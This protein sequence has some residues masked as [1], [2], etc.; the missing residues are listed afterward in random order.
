MKKPVHLDFFVD[1]MIHCAD[2]AKK[3][4]ADARR[5][6]SVNRFSTAGMLAISSLEE[7]GKI[8]LLQIFGALYFHRKEFGITEG[9]FWKEF[10]KMW[11]DHR[12]KQI[13]ASWIDLFLFDK[14]AI[15]LA[16]HSMKKGD[17][18]ELRNQFLYVDLDNS[19]REWILPKETNRSKALEFVE[20]AEDIS[21][22]ICREFNTRRRRLIIKDI[23]DPKEIEAVFDRWNKI[24]E[25]L[26]QEG[27]G[28]EGD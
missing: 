11:R 28:A 22:E 12:L 21:E 19:K 13:C 25:I 18:F 1:G 27:F 26:E 3:V 8:W 9:E 15:G 24:R 17:L 14:E 2:N 23:I 4:S 10:N 6:Y 7:I 16:K 20:A 5:L